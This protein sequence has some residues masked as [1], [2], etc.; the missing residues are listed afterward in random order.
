[1]LALFILPLLMSAL[2]MPISLSAA[3]LPGVSGM[4]F[5]MAEDLAMLSEVHFIIAAEAGVMA[6][7]ESMAAAI[8]ILNLA[9]EE[10][11]RLAGY[12]DTHC[13][14]NTFP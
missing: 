3:R 9:W 14:P 1:M 13:L 8:N 4:V 7:A 11:Q 2:A 12:R 6:K 5:I 10:N